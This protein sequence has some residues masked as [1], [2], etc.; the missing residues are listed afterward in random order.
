NRGT[1][2]PFQG[3]SVKF[4]PRTGDPGM[5]GEE[6]P[7]MSASVL[8]VD[9]DRNLCQIVAKA[10]ANEGYSVRTCHDGAEALAIVSEHLPDLLLLDAKRPR[11]A[12]LSVLGELRKS[13]GEMRELPVVVLTSE[14]TAS[15][16]ERVNELK[17][18]DL[19]TKPVA[20]ERLLEV[21]ARC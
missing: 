15:C 3:F 17:A 12:G 4:G 2:G 18:V 10:L 6:P 20:L 11:R 13:D 9:D 19:L 5:F 14:P 21:V 16:A 7:W 8:Y 1:R